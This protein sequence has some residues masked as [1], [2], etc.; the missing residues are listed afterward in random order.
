MNEYFIY[1]FYNCNNECLYVGQT[2]DLR[3]RFIQHKKDKTWWN[4]VKEIRVAETSKRLVDIYERYYIN[5]FKAK[6]NVKDINIKYKKFNFEELLF[7]K[8]FE[9]NR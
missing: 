7:E 3:K 8:L 6:Y 5:K 1:C 4:E 9:R 2:N